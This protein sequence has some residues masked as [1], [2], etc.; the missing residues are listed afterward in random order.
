[1][2]IVALC[3]SLRRDSFNR[4]LL[5]AATQLAE[6]AGARVEEGDIASLPHYNSDLEADDLPESVVVLKTAVREADALL[7]V[8]PEYNYSVPGTL[9]NAI[10]WLSR[11]GFKSVLAHRPTGILSASMSPVGGARMQGHLKSILAGTLT[12]VYPAPEF[13]LPTAQN[14]FDDESGEL[15]EERVRTALARYVGEFLAWVSAD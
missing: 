2:K 3:G 5:V 8:S 1:M 9:K 4:R 11:P 10:D 6:A 13:T 7:I 12:P 14:A 15:V